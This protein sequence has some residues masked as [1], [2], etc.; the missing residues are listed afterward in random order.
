LNS[1]K[2]LFLNLESSEYAKSERRVNKHT[3][4]IINKKK[5]TGKQHPPPAAN[6]N[7]INNFKRTA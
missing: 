7:D 3:A 2:Q 5:S 1:A 4:I 6:Q